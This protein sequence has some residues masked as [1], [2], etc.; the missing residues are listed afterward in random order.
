MQDGRRTSEEEMAVSR[1]RRDH[2]RRRTLMCEPCRGLTHV[3]LTTWRL[4]QDDALSLSPEGCRGPWEGSD[5]GSKRVRS[6]VQILAGGGGENGS[7]QSREGAGPV[8][9]SLIPGESK[10]GGLRWGCSHGDGGR[11]GFETF[12]G[13]QVFKTHQVMGS[14]G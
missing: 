12:S 4:P 3:G 1:H 2:P 13:I 5:R 8:Q 11:E 6:G 10:N 7:C 9:V 14:V